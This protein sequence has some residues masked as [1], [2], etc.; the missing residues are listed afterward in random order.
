M[1]ELLDANLGKDFTGLESRNNILTTHTFETLGLKTIIV[2]DSPFH[3]ESAL[4][5]RSLLCKSNPLPDS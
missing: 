3:N 1:Y 4:D 5:Y 2:N